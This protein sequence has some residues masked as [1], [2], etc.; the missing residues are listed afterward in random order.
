[1]S[2][3]FREV[4]TG[5]ELPTRFTDA[6]LVTRYL[7]AG[8][9]A[10]EPIYLG[11]GETW[12]EI[13]PGLAKILA[14]PMPPHSHGYVISQFGLPR[15]QKVLR[16]Y[17]AETHGLPAGAD[18]EVAATAGG[19]RNAM[20]DFARLVR[21][22]VRD[23]TPVAVVPM[24][25]WDY[26]GVFSALGYET[27]YLPLRAETGYQ[28]STEDFGV[29]DG[30]D[31]VVINAQHNPTGVNWDA[32]AVREL[33]RRTDAA[34][35]LDDAYYGVHDPGITPTSA[36]RIL[37]EEQ[38]RQ[39]WLAVRSLGKQFHCSGWGIGAVTSTPSTLDIL[40]NEELFHHGFAAAIPLQYAMAEWLENPESATFLGHMNEEYAAKRAALKTTLKDE[41]HHL[42][43]CTA[44]M[45]F[46]A[47]DADFRLRC[48]R[49]TGVLF[50]DSTPSSWLRLY[51]GPPLPVLTEAFERVAGVLRAQ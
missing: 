39:H 8:S 37:L 11:F 51:L 9:P 50:S 27:R 24:P 17:I 19:T 3:P 1:M 48:F 30:A 16:G 2:I 42:G 41:D 29:V 35:L 12:T 36:L 6:E 45:R 15:L 47:P 28:L 5:P 22:S 38:P 21:Q 33:I 44:F 26:E 46:K 34:L 32:T 7:D 20:F 23:R 4:M 10:G 49:E 18:F 31:L 13:A 25:G 14:T 40:L 43:E